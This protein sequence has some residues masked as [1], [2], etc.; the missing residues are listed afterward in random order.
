M[1]K[2]SLLLEEKLNLILVG[3][4]G[5]GKTSLLNQYTRG[6]FQTQVI[7]TVGILI[8]KLGLEYFAKEEV[9]DGKKIKIKLWDTAGQEQYKSLTKNF[10]RNANGIIIVFDV[11]NRGSFGAVK[12]WM[13]NVKD[14]SSKEI[15]IALVGNKIDL[16]REV[17]EEE[18]KLFANSYKIK[19]YDCSAKES[20]GFNDC[21]VEISS[22]ITKSIKG[23]VDPTIEALKNSNKKESST[24]SC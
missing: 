24:C 7:A 3:E 18:A 17:T 15:K 12:D 16:D 11:T 4:S 14:H 1:R 19:Y 22:E 23:E 20:R 21:V 5:V 9:I 2:R 13:Q 6:V 10:Y 8:I